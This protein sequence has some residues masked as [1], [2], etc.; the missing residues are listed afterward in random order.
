MRGPFNNTVDLVYG[1]SGLIPGAVYATG[2]CRFVRED[3]EIPLLPP[4][5]GRVAYVTLDFALPNQ[6]GISGSFPVYSTD[7]DAA[8][9]IAIPSGESPQWLVLFVEL[10]S[11]I[12]GVPYWRAHLHDIE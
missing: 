5:T 12:G 3:I 11:P 4:L 6:P 9:R 8:D 1:P 10:V 7:Y 2:P